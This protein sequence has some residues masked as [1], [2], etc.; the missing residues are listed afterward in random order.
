M[1]KYYICCDMEG[2]SGISNFK[3]MQSQPSY[4]SKLMTAEINALCLA[5]NKYSNIAGKNDEAPDILIADSHSYG[6]NID[7]CGLCSNARLV[8]GFPRSYYMMP[9]IDSSFNALFIS[10]H[11]ARAGTLGAGMDHTFSGSA[12]YSVEINGEEAGEFEIN[13]GLAGHFKVPIAF[14]S[15]D[16]K[17]IEQISVYKQR[18]GFETV[19]TKQSIARYSAILEH[20]D[21][22][23][24][25]ID[26]AVEKTLSEK[27]W[28]GKYFN[29]E[30]P[31]KVKI[32]LLNTVKT[33]MVSL[34]PVLK[35]LDG[36]SV[37]FEAADFTYFYNMFCAI[38]LI[39]WNDK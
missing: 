11:H 29:Y 38:T 16:D 28:S 13:A 10:G 12:I 17:F 36:R 25:A 7:L 27:K 35:R 8:R 6:I 9:A 23:Y 3:E 20:P 1:K 18:L 21:K 26:R 5:I 2:I 37:Y 15:G 22:V 32:T 19:V 31:L 24:S 30:Y 39:C 4:T 14:V 34:I 33:D